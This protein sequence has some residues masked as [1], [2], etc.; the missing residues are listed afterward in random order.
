MN[1]TVFD[2]II[3]KTEIEA[4]GANQSIGNH[5]L[6]TIHL[7]VHDLVKHFVRIFSKVEKQNLE[8]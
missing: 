5:F 8:N 7:Y 3:N 2:F 1:K 4:K 6:G